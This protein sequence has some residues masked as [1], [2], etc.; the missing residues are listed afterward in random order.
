MLNETQKNEVVALCQKLIQSP[1]TS[2]HEEGRGR[3]PEGVL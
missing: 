2:G 3:A 1:S